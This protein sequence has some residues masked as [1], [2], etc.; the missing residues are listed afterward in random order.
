MKKSTMKVSAATAL[1]YASLLGGPLVGNAQG[2]DGRDR[3]KERNNS[4]EWKQFHQMKEKF[5]DQERNKRHF[6]YK[7]RYK[8]YDE[9]NIKGVT[10]VKDSQMDKT[11]D[12]KKETIE[13]KPIPLVTYEQANSYGKNTILPLISAIETAKATKDWEALENYYHLLSK[14]LRKGTSI[15]YKVDGKQ[16]RESLISVYKIPAQEKRTELV[17][18]ITIY[19]ALENVN[20][21]MDKGETIN[22]SYQMEEVRALVNKLEGVDNNPLLEDLVAQVNATD[23]KLN[24]LAKNTNRLEVN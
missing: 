9:N 3:D 12:N 15:F 21:T 17:L 2:D 5:K 14:E 10:N 23:N 11:K 20:N 19:M 13:Q 8:D 22:L 16:N 1:L 4:S 24:L 7:S 18:P 6:D